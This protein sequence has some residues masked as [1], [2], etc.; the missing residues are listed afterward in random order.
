MSKL[1]IF[2]TLQV[3]QDDIYGEFDGLGVHTSFDVGDD[4]T[5]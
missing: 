2:I 1:V 4:A 3:F 5:F